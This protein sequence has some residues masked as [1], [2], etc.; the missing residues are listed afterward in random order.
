MRRM[1]YMTETLD[2]TE[3]I[4]NDLHQA[5]VSDWRFHV[6]SRD[7][8]GLYQR[9]IHS[10]NYFQ[11]L[12]IIRYAERGG[13]I[14]FV[15]A[16]FL[17]GFLMVSKPFG[18]ALH[19][20]LY[21]TIFGFITLFGVWVGGLSGVASENQQLASYHDEIT[22]GKYLLLVDVRRNELQQ[23]KALMSEKHPEAELAHVGSTIVNPFKSGHS[24]RK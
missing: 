13:M 6:H 8:A 2:S 21:L 16:M 1:Y 7:A 5:G 15:C 24:S 10:A 11:T 9:H 22:A 14:G 12:D 18:S 4:A 20:V 23:V 17:V 3:A 19:G